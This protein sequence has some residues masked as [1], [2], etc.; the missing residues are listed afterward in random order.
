MGALR[1]ASRAGGGD[2]ANPLALIGQV[3]RRVNRGRTNDVAV[4]H[5]GVRDGRRGDADV[6]EEA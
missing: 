5:A 2:E 4:E 1:R 6:V 3:K